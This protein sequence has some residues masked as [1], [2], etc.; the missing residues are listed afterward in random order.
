MHK[1]FLL[2]YPGGFPLNQEELSYMQEA[3]SESIKALT[4]VAG[5]FAILSGCEQVD[6][7]LNDGW[8]I[9]NGELL[10]FR[11]STIT[12]YITVVEEK[13]GLTYE[14]GI[15]NESKILRYAK[16]GGSGYAYLRFARIK[17]LAELSGD[18]TIADI[19]VTG[20]NVDIYT[21]KLR[22]RK[23]TSKII[24][25]DGFIR[26]TNSDS[27]PINTTAT[28]SIPGIT[29]KN[30]AF[31][32]VEIKSY[33]TPGGGGSAEPILITVQPKVYSITNNAISVTVSGTSAVEFAVNMIHV[34]NIGIELEIQ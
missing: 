18:I 27:L 7:S 19:S 13:T 20:S 17:N 34:I 26:F 9:V 14:T 23:I 8:V 10:P 28:I 5:E 22:G 15:T 6:N 25:I 30:A 33:V 24:R 16:F 21:T 31:P 3:Y 11:Q 12:N 2:T 29:L 4:A 32:A 1:S